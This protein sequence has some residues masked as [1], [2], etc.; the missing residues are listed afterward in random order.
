MNVAKHSHATQAEMYLKQTG[1]TL[2][3]TLRDNGVGFNR[4]EPA[5]PIAL[6]L[7]TME[8]RIKTLGGELLIKSS[9]AEGTKISFVVPLRPA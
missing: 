4:V 3:G 1:E 9:A 8:E 2:E 7:K 5:G 6:G